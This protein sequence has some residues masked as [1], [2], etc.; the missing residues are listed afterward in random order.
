ML[1]KVD[2]HTEEPD[3]S[4]PLLRRK[5]LGEDICGLLRRVDVGY[6]HP[7]LWLQ[8]FRDG[9]DVDLMGP[10]NVAQLG[11]VALLCHKDGRLVIFMNYELNAPSEQ[12]LPQTERWNAFLKQGVGERNY[13]TL[14]PT[15]NAQAACIPSPP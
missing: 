11:R 4:V 15:A 3:C 13:L 5:L 6:L 8:K 10:R 7:G 14:R 1:G 9:R 2:A 12:L